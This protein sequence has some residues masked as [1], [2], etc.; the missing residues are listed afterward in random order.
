MNP[1]MF[2]R[3]FIP[4]AFYL[5]FKYLIHL[6]VTCTHRYAHLCIPAALFLTGDSTSHL[7]HQHTG[8]KAALTEYAMQYEI[9]L[10]V[11]LLAT[12]L[13]Q[14]GH[15]VSNPTLNWGTPRLSR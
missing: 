7:C 5:P 6:H 11:T 14:G 3:I 12:S 9:N 4:C 15:L 13:F 1:K 10:T 8:V 2:S